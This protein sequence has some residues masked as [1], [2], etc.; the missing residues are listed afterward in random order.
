MIIS[1]MY[2]FLSFA[3]SIIIFYF[4]FHCSFIDDAY[5]EGIPLLVLTACCESE[6]KVRRYFLIFPFCE[7]VFISGKIVGLK[8]VACLAS[9]SWRLILLFH[10]LALKKKKKKG[11]SF[12]I[13]HF[14]K[15]VRCFY[16]ACT[17]VHYN[18]T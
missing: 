6:D 5:N 10:F 9:K 2:L 13:M 18:S 1:L 15:K 7:I 11:I 16:T 4:P 3:H 8:Y 14:V 17:Y 12:Q